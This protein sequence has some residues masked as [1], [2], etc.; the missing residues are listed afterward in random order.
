MCQPNIV[1]Q[2]FLGFDRSFLFCFWIQYIQTISKHNPNLP[3]L[4]FPSC[5]IL[6]KMICLST[7]LISAKLFCFMHG[8]DYDVIKELRHNDTR[9]KEKC[10]TLDTQKPKSIMRGEKQIMITD[11]VSCLDV[12]ALYII[13]FKKKTHHAPLR[14]GW[15]SCFGFFLCF[16]F[17]FCAFFRS[18]HLNLLEDWNS[19]IKKCR[20][21]KHGLLRYCF[22]FRLNS[23]YT[24][25]NQN[26][27]Q[28][29]FE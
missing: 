21:T 18:V 13:T 16:C 23:W 7:L 19:F 27:K 10:F 28:Y 22:E 3:C 29:P 11:K 26:I 20:L 15:F 5:G 4:R 17:C 25:T 2:I 1:D 6:I 9:I 12:K 14:S 24:S 8:N